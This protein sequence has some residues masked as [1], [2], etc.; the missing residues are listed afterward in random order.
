MTY[1]RR[2]IYSTA[3]GDKC[4]IFFKTR[5]R[6]RT[7]LSTPHTKTQHIVGVKPACVSNGR[8]GDARIEADSLTLRAIHNVAARTNK[9]R[10]PAGGLL[11]RLEVLTH[12]TR[13][14][15]QCRPLWPLLRP[16]AFSRLPFSP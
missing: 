9:K 15:R 2:L 10:P 14:Q 13:F 6:Q 11:K 1:R 3:F 12:P 7:V 4:M 5:R 16:K 8:T